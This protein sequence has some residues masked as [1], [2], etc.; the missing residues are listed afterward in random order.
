MAGLYTEETLRALNKNQIINLFLK[1]QEQTNSTIAS[2][3]AEIKRLNENFQ[4]LESDFSFVKNVNNI[5]L[6]QIS[7][8]ERQCGKG[9]SIRSTWMC[10]GGG[11]TFVN[12]RQRSWTNSLQGAS[13]YWCWHNHGRRYW[14]MPSS[15]E[16][17]WQNHN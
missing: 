1:T 3:T 7:S 13:A 14:S 5:L 12:W 10:C 17:E 11:V 9:P 4:K 6:K 2:L 8:I 15:E 16:T